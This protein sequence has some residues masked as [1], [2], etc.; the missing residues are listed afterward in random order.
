ML[1]PVFDANHLNAGC[2]RFFSRFTCPEPSFPLTDAAASH[3]AVNMPE[4]VGSPQKRASG[5]AQ[6]YLA[7]C[8]G[9]ALPV[10]RCRERVLRAVR[11]MRA[12]SADGLG[13]VKGLLLGVG[14]G[15]D[16][17]ALYPPSVCGM[18]NRGGKQAFS[19]VSCNCTGRRRCPP[20]PV[21]KSFRQ[22]APK[23]KHVQFGN[24]WPA[25]RGPKVVVGRAWDGP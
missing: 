11:G 3:Y 7:P 5:G 12:S 17:M 18:A 24:Q 21:V 19:P 10:R 16:H 4:T 2:T 9:A 14:S 25:S 22:R 1:V 15:V 13:N 8:S 6:A 20:L 23:M